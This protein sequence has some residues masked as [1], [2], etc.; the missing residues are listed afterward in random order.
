MK[1]HRQTSITA[2]IAQLATGSFKFDNFIYFQKT[3]L[4]RQFVLHSPS[5]DGPA[6][7]KLVDKCSDFRDVASMLWSFTERN[8]W[9]F[10]IDFW[11]NMGVLN[12]I[13]FQLTVCKNN[14]ILLS[15]LDAV[16]IIGLL[17]DIVR[18]REYNRINNRAQS[19]CICEHIK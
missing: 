16:S 12:Y 4:R 13:A 7:C 8:P 3:S 5:F 15:V 10:S 19:T 9:N 14:D 17:A 1:D 2:W 18:F 6:K 11:C